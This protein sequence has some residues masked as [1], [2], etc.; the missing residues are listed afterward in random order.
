MEHLTIQLDMT[1]EKRNKM[2]GKESDK[3]DLKLSALLALCMLFALI[4]AGLMGCSKEVEVPIRIPKLN[5]T[6]DTNL[7]IDSNGY[8]YFVLY[9]KYNQNFHRIS[10]KIT[11]DG[12]IPNPEQSMVNWDSNL[13]WTLKKGSVVGSINISYLNQYTGQWTS[14]QL[15]SMIA[16]KDYIIGTINSTSICDLE[17]GEINTVI[18]PVWEMRGDTM[19]VIAKYRVTFATKKNGMFETAWIR[20]SVVVIQ[21]IILK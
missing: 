5:L 17:T 1:N 15:P 3:K 13:F 18:A 21:K 8:P 20:D 4:A 10:G 11:V 6:L 14:S 9:D 16:Q 7:P 19:N 12:K 2:Q